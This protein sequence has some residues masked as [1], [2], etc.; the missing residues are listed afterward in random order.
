MTN[1]TDDGERLEVETAWFHMFRALIQSG[2]IATMGV[3]AFAVYAAIKAH[4]DYKS[5]ASYP[6]V[7]RLAEL[8]GLSKRQ[9][10][11]EQSK[12]VEMGYLKK[13]KIGRNN[14]Y[15]IRE[16][17]PVTKAGQPHALVS[18]DYSPNGVADIRQEIKQLVAEGLKEAASTTQSLHI[19]FLQINVNVQHASDNATAVQ[20]TAPIDLDTLPEPLRRRM[21]S[22][23]AHMKTRK[24]DTGDTN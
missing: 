3:N 21:E 14:V 12:L 7:M 4:S 2:S 10:I 6:G 22:I 18:W 8:V 24:G 11:R 13:Q 9:I 17:F 19:E 15:L 5:G 1:S 20:V 16:Q 23:Q